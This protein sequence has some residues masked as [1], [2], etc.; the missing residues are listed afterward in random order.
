MLNSCGFSRLIISYNKLLPLGVFHLHHFLSQR[1]EGRKNIHCAALEISCLSLTCLEW[2]LDLMAFAPEL[3][4]SSPLSKRH[5]AGKDTAAKTL[6][7]KKASCGQLS[8]NMSPSFRVPSFICRSPGTSKL[9]TQPAICI[10]AWGRSLH[11]VFCKE[12]RDHGWIM[13]ERAVGEVF[14]VLSCP[15]R[16]GPGCLETDLTGKFQKGSPGSC[17]VLY[18]V[19]KWTQTRWSWCHGT[20]S[21]ERNM[22]PSHKV[23]TVWRRTSARILD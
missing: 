3:W 19:A 20:A 18:K 7:A 13:G 11:A 9:G 6:R 4:T 15:D 1:V 23:Y 5:T 10:W 22:F 12:M 2:D 16:T 8:C 17:S 14:G 21:G